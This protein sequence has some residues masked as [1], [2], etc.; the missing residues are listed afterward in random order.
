MRLGI[1]KIKHYLVVEMFITV[2]KNLTSCV[3]LHLL[4][5]LPPE[6]SHGVFILFAKYLWF[7]MPKLNFQNK[8][9][10]DILAKTAKNQYGVAAGL[11]KNAT[12]I[13]GLFAMGFGF[14]EV[15]T[16][17]PKPQKGNSKPRIFRFPN[18]HSILNFMGFPNDGS[19]KILKRVQSFKKA[20]GQV[21]GVNIGRNKDGTDEDYTYLIEK[22]HK[23][24]DYITINISSPNTPNLRDTLNN[25]QKL[26]SLLLSIDGFRNQNGVITPI[27]LKLTPDITNIQEI[28]DVSCKYNIDGF[29][30][31]NTT[32]DK[33]FL[34]E[35]FQTLPMGGVSGGLLKEKSLQILK[36]FNKI[37][38]HKKFVISCGGVD[39]NAEVQER[40]KNGANAVQVYTSLIYGAFL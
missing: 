31:T 27:L 32:A 33:S 39:S 37:N 30:L 8:Q 14:V 35:E 24:C 20:E 5:I 9:S 3:A 29:I 10:V 12:A 36:E 16:V 7:L 40:I 26:E 15:G 2:V 4:R 23:Y 38:I 25:I 18:T 6:L 17:T 28:Y 34:P 22:F 11:D 13:K 21:L 1:S 19:D